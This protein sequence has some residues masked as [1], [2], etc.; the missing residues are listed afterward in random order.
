MKSGHIHRRRIVSPTD[1]SPVLQMMDIQIVWGIKSAEVIYIISLFLKIMY[2]IV[3]FA[4]ELWDSLDTVLLINKILVIVLEGFLSVI[5]W[6]ALLF[7]F[8]FMEDG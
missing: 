4:M 2:I 3:I 6:E 7:I 5:G 8:W 1:I